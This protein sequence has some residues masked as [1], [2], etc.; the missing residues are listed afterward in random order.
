MGKNRSL[1]YWIC[2]LTVI[3]SI[4]VHIYLTNHHYDFKYG[5]DV[6]GG[7]CNINEQFNCNRTTSSSYS[8]F[9]GIPISIFG[10]LVNFFLLGLLLCFRFPVVSQGTQTQLAAPIKVVSLFIF[11][12]SL[13]MGTISLTQLNTLCPAC[14]I[15]Y[16]LSLL[17]FGGVLVLTK[18]QSFISGIEKILYPSAIVGIF[19]FAYFIHHN[20]LRNFGGKEQ[21]EYMNLQLQEW[22]NAPEQNLQVV[23]PVQKNPSPS[24]KMKVVEFADFLCGHCATAFPTVKAFINSHPDVEFSFQ[25]FPLDGACNKEIQYSEGTRCYLAA[26]SQCAHRQGQAWKTQEWIFNNQRQLLSKDMVKTMLDENAASLGLDKEQLVQ[27]AESE[28]V[29]E[30]IRNQAAAGAT[31]GV[32][33]TPS[34]Y[35]NGKKVPG[36]FTIPLLQKIYESLN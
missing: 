15:A 6:S 33:G 18:G 20:K 7:I 17:T 19:A 23:S 34:L 27:C 3:G 32:K 1:V 4:G 36:G 22:Q 25:A 9:F 8:E 12:T 16:F 26:I 10:G 2:L 24:A 21:V 31:A 13:V 29:K 11:L 28:E 14:S 35:V 30:I 5:Q